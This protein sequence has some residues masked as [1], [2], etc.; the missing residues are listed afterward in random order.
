MYTAGIEGTLHVPRYI[1][2]LIAPVV[3][4][5]PPPSDALAT[6][7]HQMLRVMHSTEDAVPVVHHVE[8]GGAG[9]AVTQDI[10]HHRLVHLRGVETSDQEQH[11]LTHF[12]PSLVPDIVNYLLLALHLKC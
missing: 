10:R 12:P 8:G 9:G 7:H 4:L 11:V 1:L 5:P 6:V 2:V 3:P